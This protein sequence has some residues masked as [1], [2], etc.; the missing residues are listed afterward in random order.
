MSV[1]D[2]VKEFIERTTSEALAD[3]RVQALL[4]GEMIADEVRAFFRSFIVTHLNSVQILSFLFSI[5]PR[6]PSDLVKENLLEEMGLEESE[7]SHPDMLID[8]ARGL[9]FSQQD[10]LRLS[11]EADEVR[12][13]FS[14]SKIPY[15]TLR[16]LGLS[17]LLETVAFEFFLSRVSDSMAYAMTGHYGL[18]AGA[19]QWF[20]LHGEVDIKH[21]EEGKQTI[22]SYV[23]YYRFQPDEFERIARKTFA[24]N[25]VLNRYFPRCS[26]STLKPKP[27]GIETLEI[28]PLHIPFTQAFVHSRTS[29]SNSDSVIVRLKGSDG[30]TGYG[31]ALPRPY[32]TGEDVPRMVEALRSKLGPKAMKLN[33]ESGTEALDQIQ[34]FIEGCASLDPSSSDVVAWNATLCALELA[35][36]D[37]TFKRSGESISNWLAPARG[38]VVYTGVIDAT[39]PETAGETAGRYARAKFRTLKVKVGVDDDMQRLEAVRKAAGDRIEIRVDANGAWTPSE[40]VLALKRLRAYDISAVE[41]PVP[42][43]DLEGMLRVRNE[44]GVTVIADESLVTL[45]DAASLI[46][47]EACDAFNIRVSKCG[48]LLASNRI[49]QVGLDAGIQVQVGA[50]VGET[51]LLSA[52][53][54]HLAAH[55]PGVEYV[56]GSF[57]THL[58]SEDISPEPVMFGYEGR[59]DLLLGEGLGVKVDDEALE[60]LADDI[61]RVGGGG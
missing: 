10:I 1:E 48:G 55:L 23:S 24:E 12:R 8:L 60:R 33:L 36:L 41:Q 26:H 37:W 30:L 35:L 27:S 13:R 52:A 59:G 16:D 40:A 7:K 3:K 9:G 29:R 5:V 32:V 43:S 44:T 15:G 45:N 28:L 6:G 14:S 19:V 2:D 25:V 42:A 31:E 17:I 56:E 20:T 58:L 54:R 21:A 49:A 50:Q 61:V 34:S 53:G 51:S 11:A 18:S 46:R 47:M 38:H 39:D 4:S 22:L 57:G